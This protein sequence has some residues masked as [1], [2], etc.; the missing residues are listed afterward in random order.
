MAYYRLYFLD[1]IDRRITSFNELE[2]A[3]DAEALAAAE[4]RRGPAGM[5]LWCE[6]RKVRHWRP[7]ETVLPDDEPAVRMRRRA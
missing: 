1:G 2:A 6:G 4:R 5:E 3:S 7:L